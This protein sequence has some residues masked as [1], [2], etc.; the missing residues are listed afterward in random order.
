MISPPYFALDDEALLAHLAAAAHACAPLPF[1]V[2]E[3][4]ARSGYAVPVRV[5]EQL[6][7][8]AP[9]PRRA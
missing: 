1:Y 2:Y 3:F 8:A 6:R 9:E 5:L 4:Q 7:E